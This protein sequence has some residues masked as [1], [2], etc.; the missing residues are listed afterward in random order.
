M[1]L[2]KTS[3]RELDA[4]TNSHSML[5][6]LVDKHA[7]H[8]ESMGM[9]IMLTGFHTQSSNFTWYS[10]CLQAVA[11]KYWGNCSQVDWTCYCWKRSLVACCCL[12]VDHDN[13]TL[14]SELHC[15]HLIAGHTK[16]CCRFKVSGVLSFLHT[17]NTEETVLPHFPGEFCCFAAC[18]KFGGSPLCTWYWRNCLSTK[19]CTLFTFLDFTC[20]CSKIFTARWFFIPHLT[21]CNDVVDSSFSGTADRQASN[22]MLSGPELY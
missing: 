14:G 5:L 8:A 6:K 22:L 12:H 19:I 11:L 10:A 2:L 20:S 9:L 13:A 18:L 15:L 7:D 4:H 17:N 16:C 3:L 1:L 21:P